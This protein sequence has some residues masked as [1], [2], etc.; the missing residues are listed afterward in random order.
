[1]PLASRYRRFSLEGQ[2][3]DE[4]S[5]EAH[6]LTPAM[7]PP[8]LDDHGSIAEANGDVLVG[9]SGAL[10]SSASSS[11]A[12]VLGRMRGSAVDDASP[13]G[14]MQLHTGLMPG[15]NSRFENSGSFNPGRL[16]LPMAAV[17]MDVNEL[18]AYT[19]SHPN[20]YHRE[21]ARRLLLSMRLRRV[22]FF[23][24][25][26]FFACSLVVC[27][28]NLMHLVKLWAAGVSQPEEEPWLQ[29]ETELET[30]IGVAVC[31]ETS[32]TLW[33]VGWRVFC[34][35]YWC[36]LDAL[37]TMLIMANWCLLV[38]HW[39]VLAY[40]V[41]SIDLPVVALRF[42]LQPCRV[43][44][45]LSMLRR[46][47][48]MQ[49]STVDVELELPE[50]ELGSSPLNTA[51]RILT[52]ELQQA[53]SEHLPPWLRYRAWRLAYSPDEH[54]ASMAAFYRSQQ[55]AVA[56]CEPGAG[57]NVVLVREAS[58]AVFGGFVSEEWRPSLSAYSGSS[59]CFVFTAA[60]N[61]S[62]ASVYRGT[63]GNVLLWNNSEGISLGT[64][65]HVVDS[66]RRGSTAPCDVFGSPALLAATSCSSAT[67]G[68]ATDFVV[69]HFECWHFLPE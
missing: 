35:D 65:L 58:G 57:A 13:A 15:A 55:A 34:R 11:C 54:G 49:A 43:L 30:A 61:D 62:V 66:F 48:Q 56:G 14:E 59:D 3:E 36:I 39:Y 45:A 68:G 25:A 40:E 12:A 1:M 50:A 19:K 53:I 21:C 24:C 42:L 32:T 9:S 46:V 37:V 47:R 44:A 20:R 6:D 26:V 63:R 10:S 5:D 16:G 4:G 8:L 41:M 17:H 33:L 23:Y 22:Y 52:P 28:M 29:W 64:A 51:S 69:R 38:L 2:A 60:A 18:G 7:E 67:A 31:L 27:F